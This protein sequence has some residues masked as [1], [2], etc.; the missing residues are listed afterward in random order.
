MFGK[1]KIEINAILDSELESLL[2]Q[3]SQ[4]E[5]LIQGYIKCSSCGTTITS[6]NIGVIIPITKESTISLEFYCEK[7]NCMEKYKTNGQV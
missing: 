2:M 5:D 7:I 4:Y 3:T 1:K 6:D